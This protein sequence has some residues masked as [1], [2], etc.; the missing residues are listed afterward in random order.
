[1][2]RL[3]SPTGTY[4]ATVTR[5]DAL[6]PYVEAP[7]VVPGHEFGPCLSVAGLRAYAAGDRVL[8][9]FLEDRV[10]ELV[11][12]GAAGPAPVLDP[13][14]QA[15]LDA[16]TGRLATLEASPARFRAYK[17]VSF[18]APTGAWQPIYHDTVRESVGTWINDNA[19]GRIT[20]KQPGVY[21]VSANFGWGATGGQLRAIAIQ[22][23]GATIDPTAWIG[24]ADYR[25]PAPYPTTVCHTSGEGVPMNGVSDFFTLFTYQ[26]AGVVIA[27][28]AGPGYSELSIIRAGNL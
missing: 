14:T 9:A 22:K 18:N 4:T 23:N 19:T 20:P 5:V 24:G 16:A 15:E 25:G 12:L 26:D 8:V 3:E 21:N 17:A 10:D 1:M 6:G 27:T 7:R 11:I 13:A 28:M 2:A